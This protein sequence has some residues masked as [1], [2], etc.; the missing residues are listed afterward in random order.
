MCECRGSRWLGV[1]DGA[2][3]LVGRGERPVVV[4]PKDVPSALD[5]RDDTFR[6]VSADVVGISASVHAETHPVVG[7]RRVVVQSNVAV[8]DD[9]DRVLTWRHRSSE[10]EQQLFIFLYLENSDQG[11]KSKHT[12]N[13]LRQ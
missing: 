7:E 6:V 2:A 5:V 4:L 3:E 10:S 13:K 1:R 8:R 12:S 11:F 9:L